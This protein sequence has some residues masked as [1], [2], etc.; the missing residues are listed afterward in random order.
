MSKVPKIDT[1]ELEA[2]RLMA[3]I[4]AS[5]KKRLPKGSGD[6]MLNAHIKATK[7][8]VW[9]LHYDRTMTG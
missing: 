5:M 2:N 1:V 3:K 7:Q 6:D 4:M 9:D 8:T